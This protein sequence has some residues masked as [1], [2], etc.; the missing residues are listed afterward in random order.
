[1]SELMEAGG[2]G[3]E[4]RAENK[5]GIIVEGSGREEDGS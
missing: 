1:M 4:P 3:G 2:G 5:E